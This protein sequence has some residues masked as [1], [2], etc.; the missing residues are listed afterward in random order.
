MAGQ[1]QVAEIRAVSKS[2]GSVK[3]LV[4]VDF[5]LSSGEVR[6]LLGKNGAGKS[7]LIR[8]LSGAETP[9]RG[10]V[11]VGGAG[12]GEGGVSRAHALGV[13]TVYQ[14]LSLV[15][16]MSVAENMF[17]GAWTRRGASLDF[18]AMNA[19]TREALEPFELDIDPTTNVE[20][21]SAAD[22]QMVEIARAIRDE[23]RLLILDEPT[24]SLATAEVERVLRTVTRIAEAGVA[25]IYVSH[26]L[27]E[28]RQIARAASIMRD[29]R[30]VATRELAAVDTQEVVKMMIGEGGQEAATV[31][32]ARG[33]GEPT[34][35]ELR[36]VSASPNLESIDLQLHATEVLGIA[37]VLGSG[38]TEILQVIAGIRPLR[39]GT[40]RIRGED[41]TGEGLA[42]ALERGV[43]ITPESRKELGIFPQLGVDENMMVSKWSAVTQWGV[44]SAA[45]VAE[46]ARGL[47]DRLHIKVSSPRVEIE[48]LSGG[49]QQKAVIG[50]W[51]HADSEIL[52]LDEPTRGVDVEAKAQ[53]YALVRGLA[54]Q[55][56]AV[57][58]VSSE[59]EELPAVCDRVVVLRGGR[60]VREFIAPDI[61]V[62]ILLA[63]AMAEH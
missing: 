51:L 54:E 44:I 53:I 1:D 26:R 16:S 60:I 59:I 40:V 42:Q 12:L 10:E 3:A 27:G 58:F 4:D 43:G 55:G 37:G 30:L 20:D 41:T 17:M 52:L 24:S 46:R 13:R 11:L 61:D 33:N 29:G 34:V 32:H 63:E 36:E 7:T 22:Q 50:R 19:M 38:R 28:I 8:M 62:D 18:K 49:N 31:G 48:T 57:V 47:I 35:L 6:A 9:D 21:L 5:T 45:A 23:P 14:E 39:S 56:R 2:Y 15:G 25:V